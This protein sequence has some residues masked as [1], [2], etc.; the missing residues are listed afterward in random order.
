MGFN[1][2]S[3]VPAKAGTHNPGDDVSSTLSNKATTADPIIGD[4]AYGSLPS[5]GRRRIRRREGLTLAAAI[6]ISTPPGTSGLLAFGLE[7]TDD[8]IDTIERRP[9]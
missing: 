9:R 2:L 8:G 7:N 4:T 1:I 5:R 6:V 3:V